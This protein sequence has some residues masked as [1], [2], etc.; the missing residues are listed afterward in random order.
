MFRNS[1]RFAAFLLAL[2]T[3]GVLRADDLTTLQ[4]RLEQIEADNQQLRA[5]LEELQARESL[6]AAPGSAA[7]EQAA[8]APSA[9]ED[10]KGFS[11]KWNNGFEA[12][13][14]DKRF[15]YHVGGRVQFDSVFLADDQQAL[16]GTGVFTDQ[17]AIGFRRARLRADGT[18]Y[19]TID[20]CAEFDFVNSV[21]DNLPS[22]PSESTVIGVPAP[23]DLWV[24]FREVPIV[25]N[26]R[27][28]D[29]KEPMGFEHLTSSRYLDFMERSYNQDIFYGAFNN[30]FTP[31]VVVYDTWADEQGT[32]ST[33]FF[34]NN[35][36][37]F[38]YG[39]GEGEYAW[40]SRATALL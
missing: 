35:T 14:K 31:G 36:N 19:D 30:G 2:G 28:G 17:D 27:V 10:P 39:V 13:S 18:M 25:G 15:K 9:K 11:A 16:A 40:T 6:L 32:W 20:W 8:P 33:G 37:V 12:I 23:T 7:Q 4:S 38:G 5:E 1:R 24:T 26:V 3:T 22:P 34:K 21:N 29:V